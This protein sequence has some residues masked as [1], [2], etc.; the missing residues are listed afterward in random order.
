MRYL[1]V[2]LL[3]IVST[4]MTPREIKTV[5]TIALKYV[6]F[7]F[8]SYA[9]KDSSDEREFNSEYKALK[10][11]LSRNHEVL[12]TL[13][14]FQNNRERDDLAKQRALKILNDM[15]RIG[16]EKQRI[17]I[18]AEPIVAITDSTDEAEKMLSQ[19]VSFTLENLK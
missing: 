1:L 2:I 18:I 10:L 4:A 7:D 11:F 17:I 19:K 14:S 9:Y 12:L 5:H 15:I 3:L 13:H 16:C 8:N 6:F